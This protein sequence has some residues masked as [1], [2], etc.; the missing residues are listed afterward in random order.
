MVEE[1][2]LLAN[3][4]VAKESTRAFP[5]YAMLRRHPPPQPG[6]FDGLNASLSQHGCSLD[7]GSAAARS[8]NKQEFEYASWI[9]YCMSQRAPMDGF[10]TQASRTLSK[11]CRVMVTL[12]GTT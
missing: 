5:Q 4:S 12:Y 10:Q 11:R 1:F 9:H 2:M 6:A 3:I 8:R 7:A